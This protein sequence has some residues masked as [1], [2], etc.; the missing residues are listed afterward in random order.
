MKKEKLHDAL[1]LLDDDLIEQV[2]ELRRKSKKKERKENRRFWLKTGIQAACLCVVVLGILSLG[3]FAGSPG[4]LDDSDGSGNEQSAEQ[5]ENAGSQDVGV[6]IPKTK[7]EVKEYLMA[8]VDMIAFFIYQGRS[9]VQYEWIDDGESLVGEYLGTATGTIDEWTK[10]DDYVELSG[11]IGGDFY[12]VNGY[13]TAFMLCMKMENG[14]ISTYINDNGITL[15]KGSELFEQRLQLAGNYETVLYQT[16]ENWFY[17]LGEKNEIKDEQLAVTERFVEALN[18]AIF[19]EGTEI[20]VDED[21]IYHM[22]FEM[23][24][25]MTVHLRLY[26]GGYVRFQGIWGAVAKMDENIFNE[27]IDA[28]KLF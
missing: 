9:Y 5:A 3:K 6:T 13:D 16:R 28:M 26:K 14:N 12:S 22:F 17:D 20:S 10:E 25:G 19:V 11:S 23:K 8:E 27:M 21:E 2:D 15:T 1:N 7:M 24:N 18:D 4:A